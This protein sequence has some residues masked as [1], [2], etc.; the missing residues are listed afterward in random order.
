[1]KCTVSS[2]DLCPYKWYEQPSD[3]ALTC[4][5]HGSYIRMKCSIQSLESVSVTWFMTNNSDDAGFDG[6]QIMEGEP[7]SI[8]PSKTE[9]NITFSSLVFPAEECTF[10]YYWCEIT[11]P[12]MN[13]TTSS[14]IVAVISNSS[15]P[16]CSDIAMP[17]DPPSNTNTECAVKG[18]GAS[19]IASSNP[20]TNLPTTLYSTS[21]TD[22]SVSSSSMA[23]EV[24]LSKHDML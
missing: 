21:P 3:Q 7:F 2:L 22:N 16:L 11:F 1:M 24:F 13:M 14:A 15:L 5:P 20:S 17:Y 4:D 8:V 23:S 9:G 6:N 10:G 12:S 19:E 18:F